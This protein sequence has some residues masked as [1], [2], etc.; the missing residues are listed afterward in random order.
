MTQEVVK[1]CIVKQDVSSYSKET[2]F[3]VFRS[4]FYNVRLGIENVEAARNKDFGKQRHVEKYT[5]NY[6]VASISF[7]TKHQNN[8]VFSTT[9]RVIRKLLKTLPRHYS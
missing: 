1:R 4:D 9:F 2:N 3:L 8:W 5:Q 7:T 6:M